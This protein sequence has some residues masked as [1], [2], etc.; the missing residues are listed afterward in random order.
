[1]ATKSQCDARIRQFQSAYAMAAEC[2][3]ELLRGVPPLSHSELASDD[4][5]GLRDGTPFGTADADLAR[6]AE[7]LLLVEWGA[8]QHRPGEESPFRYCDGYN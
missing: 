1:M 3:R 6:E 2:E 8:F 4:A 5:F 7:D